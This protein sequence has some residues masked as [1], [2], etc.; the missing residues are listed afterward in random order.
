VKEA[1]RSDAER[2]DDMRESLRRIEEIVHGLTKEQ[3][4][5]NLTAQDAVSFRIM[6][7]GEAA[8][9]MSNRTRNAHLAVPWKRISD[10]RHQ[11]AH[12]YFELQPS[13][14]WEFVQGDLS[15]LETKLRKIRAAP[16]TSG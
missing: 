1:A 3:F 6:A 15:R 14:I 5:Q 7:L 12:A 2:L 16:P 11:P 10:F 8:G 4:F 13:R 9:R